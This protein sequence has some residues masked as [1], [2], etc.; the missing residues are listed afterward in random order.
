M[1]NIHTYL[2]YKVQLASKM[3]NYHIKYW[4]SAFHSI[5]SHSTI[6]CEWNCRIWVKHWKDESSGF[7]EWSRYLSAW[8]C[9][10]W[11]RHLLTTRL[12]HSTL[13]WFGCYE[14]RVGV[15]YFFNIN[16]YCIYLKKMKTFSSTLLYLQYNK[17]I[18]LFVIPNLK[19]TLTVS[20]I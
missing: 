1:L 5:G 12:F 2:W 3:H 8:T 19:Y 9:H 16:H 10:L 15:L 7:S 6:C 18:Y 17:I 4:Y 20:L 14:V 13:L 11:L